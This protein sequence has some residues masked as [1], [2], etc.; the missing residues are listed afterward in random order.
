MNKR[1][2]WPLIG[3]LV[4]ALACSFGTETPDS[5]DGDMADAVAATL[6]ALASGDGQPTDDQASPEPGETVQ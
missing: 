4:A 6:T 3:M 2:L 1:Y 5:G